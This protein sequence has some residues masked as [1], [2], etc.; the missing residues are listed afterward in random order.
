MTSQFTNRLKNLAKWLLVLCTGVTAIGCGALEPTADA[1][2]SAENIVKQ[3][4]SGTA[5]Y[6]LADT[7]DTVL[8]IYV[9]S[10]S[11]AGNPSAIIG[12]QVVESPTRGSHSFSVEYSPEDIDPGTRYAVQGSLLQDNQLVAINT[13]VYPTLT[14]G[15]TDYVGYVA[16]EPVA[17]NSLEK[18]QWLEVPAPVESVQVNETYRGYSIGIVSYLP[19][20]CYKFKGSEMTRGG[21]DIL[22]LYRVNP[23]ELSTEE[24]VDV[25]VEAS[26]SP[27]INIEVTNF[28]R[29]LG[30]N[31]IPSGCSIG[32]SYAETEIPFGVKEL[33]IGKTHN[34]TVNDTLDI[35]FTPR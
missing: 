1:N 16:L 20:G 19:N 25:L 7:A 35:T 17:H 4:V 23:V 33:R 13:I 11:K 34:I 28:K 18:S 8:E 6:Q 12:K 32:V 2:V 27:D 29:V 22:K 21:S 26:F 9:V 14:Y 3:S 30:D 24:L 15:G 31:K 10:V 5:T